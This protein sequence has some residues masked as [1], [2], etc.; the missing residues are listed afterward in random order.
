METHDKEM[1]DE[2][3]AEKKEPEEIEE[4]DGLTCPNC[5]SPVKANW[6]LCPVCGAELG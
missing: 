4:D 2:M 1:R 5:Q 3:L 6:K